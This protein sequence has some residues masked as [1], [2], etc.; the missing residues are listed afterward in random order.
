MQGSAVEL[1]EGAGSHQGEQTRPHGGGGLTPGGDQAPFP[2][3]FAV[4]MTQQDHQPA[5]APQP[6]PQTGDSDQPIGRRPHAL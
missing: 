5:R 3:T 6:W 2:E 1:R 4:P